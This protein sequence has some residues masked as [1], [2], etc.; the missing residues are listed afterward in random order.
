MLKYR[1]TKENV[2]KEWLKKNGFRINRMFSD[3]DS[4][5]YTYRFPVYKHGDFN[6]LECEL[7]AILKT[8]EVRIDVYATNTRDKYASFYN[9]EYGNCDK[10]LAQIN[11]KIEDVL[12]KLEFQKGRIN[13]GNGDNQ[14]K[15]FHG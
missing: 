2:S 14:D 11:S 8:G 15:I 9:C 12:N 13:N 10:M 4:E 6:I 5:A 7:T 3:E 1:Y